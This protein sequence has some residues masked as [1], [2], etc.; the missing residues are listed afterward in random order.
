M[1]HRTAKT[2]YNE[3]QHIERAARA[4]PL[5][6]KHIALGEDTEASTATHQLARKTNMK[7]RDIHVPK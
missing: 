2:R 1:M 4:D 3:R 7:M 5:T 6:T